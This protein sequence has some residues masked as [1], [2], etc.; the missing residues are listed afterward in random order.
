MG[1]ATTRSSTTTPSVGDPIEHHVTLLLQSSKVPS[2]WMS[3]RRSIHSFQE[4]H[5]SHYSSP[6]SLPYTPQAVA[7]FVSHL[8]L[9]NQAPS[10][11]A[12]HLSAIAHAHKVLHLPDPTQSYLV[13]QI[14][15][16]HRRLH[17]TQDT[18]QPITKSILHTLLESIPLLSSNPYM[19]SLC[20]R[21]FLYHPSKCLSLPST[22]GYISCSYPSIFRLRP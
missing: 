22:V 10:T 4:F 5:L 18:R 20:P 12:T 19:A 17:P 8:S 6:G 21:F 11:I 1:Q 15:L 2:T 3:Y 16:G 13:R 7:A 14:Q 9:L